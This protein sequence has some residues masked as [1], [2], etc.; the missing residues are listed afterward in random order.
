[1]DL[2]DWLRREC[3]TFYP[4]IV[5]RKEASGDVISCH[6]LSREPLFIGHE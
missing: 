6:E 3:I 4:I 2:G 1:M 5:S